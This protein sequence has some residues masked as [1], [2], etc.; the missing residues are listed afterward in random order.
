MTVSNTITLAHSNKPDF[1]IQGSGVPNYLGAVALSPDGLTAWVPSKQDN[2]LRGSLR[3][4]ANLNFQNTVRAIASRIDLGTGAEELDSRV[5]LDNASL[6]SAAA[7]D[8]FGNY[9]FVALETSREVA[10]AGCAG[11]VRDLPLHRGPRAAGP[12]RVR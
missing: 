10:V 4:G 3:N 11:P 5:D 6:A 9:L 7:F 8:P 1:E 12:G 2:V